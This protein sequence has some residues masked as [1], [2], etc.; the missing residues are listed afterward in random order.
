MTSE[1]TAVTACTEL[2]SAIGRSGSRGAPIL[3]LNL[4]SMAR[5]YELFD[6][7]TEV[8]SG[9]LIVSGDPASRSGALARD[10]VL[11]RSA[12]AVLGHGEGP[13]QDLLGVS[14]RVR[15]AV[16]AHLRD[17]ILGLEVEDPPELEGLWTLTL[18][19]LVA[20]APDAAHRQAALAYAG[21]P[22]TMGRADRTGGAADL[23]SWV[24]D[25]IDGLA[26]LAGF[27]LASIPAAQTS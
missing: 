25:Q 2:L 12:A 17:E 1:P 8:R 26:S 16:T 4:V 23:Q 15:G 19:A 18:H 7:G 13:V 6:F 27:E 10:L 3:L 20:L 11:A 24:V 14:N 5:P 22:P 9:R 21:I